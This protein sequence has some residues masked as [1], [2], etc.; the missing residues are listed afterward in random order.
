MKKFGFQF[1]AEFFNVFNIQNYNT[2]GVTYGGSDF[3]VITRWLLE[4]R[5]GRYS[6]LG[7]FTSNRLHEYA[8]FPRCIR[9]SKS[10]ATTVNKL[11]Q[12]GNVDIMRVPS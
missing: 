4:L 12:K 5:R 10:G 7:K 9:G 8:S 1:R 2:P 6:S 3:G 11:L